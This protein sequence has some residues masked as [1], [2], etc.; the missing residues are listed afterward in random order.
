MHAD[1]EVL[2]RCALFE[3]ER[4]TRFVGACPSACGHGERMWETSEHERL[5]QI[6]NI[7]ANIR[8]EVA[9]AGTG[10]GGSV[11]LKAMRRT[12]YVFPPAWKEVR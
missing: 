2:T 4:Q 7:P 11:P 5:H 3:A 10:E 8:I 12:L 9:G 6:T 1:K